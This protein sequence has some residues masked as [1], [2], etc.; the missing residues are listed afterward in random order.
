MATKT[1]KPKNSPA[2][3]KPETPAEESAQE[4]AKAVS[5]AA[6][7]VEAG[8]TSPSG[9]EAVSPQGETD[10]GAPAAFE[11]ELDV[12]QP[13]TPVPMITHLVVA[14]RKDGFRRAGRAWTKAPTTVAIEEFSDEQIESLLEEPMLAIHFELR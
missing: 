4:A 6:P 5:L 10:Q 8:V 3:A 9:T 14:A 1:T 12:A 11:T 13:V 7:Q 2:P